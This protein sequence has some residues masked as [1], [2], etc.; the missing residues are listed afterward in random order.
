MKKI[1]IL[2]I[3][4][5]VVIA[6]Q[7]I[8]T[9]PRSL[10]QINIPNNA[11]YV[12]YVDFGKLSY[13]DRLYIYNVRKKKC[14]YSA[15][16]QHGNGGKSTALKPEFSNEVGSNCSSLGLYKVTK[17]DKMNS[18]K[19]VDCL[20]LRGLSSTNSNAEKRGILVH[21]GFT[22]SLIPKL[23]GLVIPLNSE[24]KGCFTVSIITMQVLKHYLKEGDIYIY[25][26]N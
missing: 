2:S 17:L 24:S 16:V 9:E 13:N 15:R 23:P 7:V 25:A 3:C 20:R 5:I 11:R 10:S 1:I 22:L 12:C 4:I 6:L 18:N 26:Y 19:H 8:T 14:V 21:P